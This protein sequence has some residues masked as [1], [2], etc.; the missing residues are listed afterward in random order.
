ME[1]KSM[2][3]GTRYQ[4][5]FQSELEKLQK[6]VDVC[7]SAL[8]EKATSSHQSKIEELKSEA[9]TQFEAVRKELSEKPKL[10]RSLGSRSDDDDSEG[11][12]AGFP[13]PGLSGLPGL[14]EFPGSSELPGL[15]DLPGASEIPGFSQF[16]GISKRQALEKRSAEES[17]EEACEKGFEYVST[18]FHGFFSSS[19]MGEYEAML[20]PLLT[21]TTVQQV[22][23]MF[24]L[25]E[26]MVET[27]YDNYETERAHGVQS[28]QAVKDLLHGLMGQVTSVA[29]AKER[30]GVPQSKS[31]RK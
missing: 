19:K 30:L 25:L 2:I 28:K 3:T 29:A 31:G 16:P 24:T 6:N 15:S 20:L 11:P 1:Q 10:R 5:Y 27:Q 9:D 18:I 8:H 23:E 13:L 22:M 14:P 7:Y 26:D 12:A 21:G 4:S 17:I